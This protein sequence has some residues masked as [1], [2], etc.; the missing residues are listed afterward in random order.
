MPNFDNNSSND[1]DYDNGQGFGQMIIVEDDDEM[2]QQIY[3][4][5]HLNRSLDG[6]DDII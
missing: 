5:D 4:D 3:I 2:G 1:S 6:D